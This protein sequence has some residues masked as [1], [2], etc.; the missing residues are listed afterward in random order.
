RAAGGRESS[1]L[2]VPRPAP[3]TR[4]RTREARRSLR[5]G[6][7]GRH[8]VGS[9]RG[10]AQV[11]LLIDSTLIVD[12]ERRGWTTE[13]LIEHVIRRWGDVG[14]AVSVM[15]AGELFHGCW[16]AESPARRAAREE[17]IE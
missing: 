11:G 14:L 9:R 10:A 17:F 2:G 12:A 6:P 16:R 8:R 15:S 13:A 3:R 1:R 4:T 7:H 5:S